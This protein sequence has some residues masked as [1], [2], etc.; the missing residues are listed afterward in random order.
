MRKIITQPW[1]KSKIVKDRA[2]LDDESSMF[3]FLDYS[4]YSIPTI[5]INKVLKFVDDAKRIETKNELVDNYLKCYHDNYVV[6]LTVKLL[7]VHAVINKILKSR[8]FESL[9]IGA[10]SPPMN[11]IVC[12]LAK[13]YKISTYSIPQVFLKFPKISTMLPNAS[14]ILVSGDRVKKEFIKY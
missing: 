9:I 2:G 12:N 6:G 5:E 1:F 3:S 8:K 10:D 7:I 4:S 11:N 14:K 13:H